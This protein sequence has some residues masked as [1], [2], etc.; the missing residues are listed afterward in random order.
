MYMLLY[1]SLF[2]PLPLLSFFLPAPILTYGSS[3]PSPQALDEVVEALFR[4][5]ARPGATTPAV[6]VI[7]TD[8]ICDRGKGRDRIVKPSATPEVTG[9]T[10]YHE[11]QPNS[12]L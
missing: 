12:R 5:W 6:D 10:I 2:C 8:D 9:C 3:S 4:S 7:Y 1:S 11:S